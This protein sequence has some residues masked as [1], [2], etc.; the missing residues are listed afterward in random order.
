MGDHAEIIKGARAGALTHQAQRLA[1]GS[2]RCRVPTDMLSE[3][4]SG[5]DNGQG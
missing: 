3:I 5:W 4:P 1:R 2:I